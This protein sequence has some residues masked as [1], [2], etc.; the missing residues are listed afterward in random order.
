MLLIGMLLIGIGQLAS[1]WDHAGSTPSM[2]ARPTRRVV[3]I[4]R[5]A[6]GNARL[7]VVSERVVHPD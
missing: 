5:R 1:S 7:A 3:A 2:S 6:M 4:R